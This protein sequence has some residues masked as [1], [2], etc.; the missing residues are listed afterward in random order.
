MIWL[1]IALVDGRF[2]LSYF[3][4]Y[5]ADSSVLEF[6]STFRRERWGVRNDAGRATRENWVGGEKLLFSEIPW[7][8][9]NPTTRAR[10]LVHSGHVHG[11]TLWRAEKAFDKLWK[12]SYNFSTSL[13]TS[14][15]LFVLS[16]ATTMKLVGL[17]TR[18]ASYERL[19][20][21]AFVPALSGIRKVYSHW[22][23]CLWRRHGREIC[24]CVLSLFV[25]FLETNYISIKFLAT[26]REK[27]CIAI[28]KIKLYRAIEF[29]KSVTRLKF[30]WIC[31]VESN[32]II[33]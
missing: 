14:I 26:I 33:I 5:G 9:P 29:Y 8:F 12:S 19:I 32:L 16:C 18:R 4:S 15:P 28:S 7:H 24:P 20:V 17:T 3:R 23:V 2:N 31:N 22:T 25:I 13:F 27:C 30:I 6:L 10:K 21:V 1:E 11:Q